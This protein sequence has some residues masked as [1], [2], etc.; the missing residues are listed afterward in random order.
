MKEGKGII[1]LAII[2]LMFVGCLLLSASIQGTS[3]SSRIKRT[4]EQ[5]VDDKIENLS[6]SDCHIYWIGDC[7]DKLLS[8]GDKITVLTQDEISEDTLPILWTEVS[9]STYTS[10]G[11]LESQITP[12]DYANHMLIVV[13][14]VDLDDDSLEI[15]QNCGV[16]NKVPILFIS[17]FTVA[18]FRTY[19]NW[20]NSSMDSIT[21]MLFS[22]EYG[23]KDNP[24]TTEDV[25]ELNFVSQ[26][27]D[28]ADELFGTVVEPVVLTNTPTPEETSAAETN[29]SSAFESVTTD[30]ETVESIG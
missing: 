13:N 9:F 30:F 1:Y 17:D 4:E 18:Q 15:L 5:E 10:D 3:A 28:L 27:L 24:I 21:S 23:S 11:E 2:L 19:I 29:T 8:L 26:I 16:K 7:P 25:T 6:A 20:V 14:A 22:T 12:R